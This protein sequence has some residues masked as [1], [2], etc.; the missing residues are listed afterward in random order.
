[1]IYEI[2]CFPK[3]AGSVYALGSSTSTKRKGHMLSIKNVL[4]NGP[5]YAL[6]A[7]AAC[8]KSVRV[9]DFLMGFVS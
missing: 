4:A 6:S 7:V 1:M 5:R 2:Y 9:P 3:G 8:V